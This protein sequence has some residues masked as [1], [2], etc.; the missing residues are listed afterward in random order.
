MW[1]VLLYLSASKTSTPVIFITIGSNRNW[2]FI[3]FWRRTAIWKYRWPSM[4]SA[5]KIPPR[6]YLH[7]NIVNYNS[8]TNIYLVSSSF[9]YQLY[10][11]LNYIKLGSARNKPNHCLG[12]YFKFCFIFFSFPT[13]TQLYV[14]REI[15]FLE[16]SW[17]LKIFKWKNLTNWKCNY[18]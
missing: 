10:V 14:S 1:K 9:V 5:W 2:L 17:Q 7:D 6:I 13:I 11:F 4:S 12:S 8:K 3:A 16:W 18:T 15:F